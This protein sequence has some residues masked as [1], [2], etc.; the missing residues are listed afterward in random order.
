M[1]KLSVTLVPRLELLTNIPFGLMFALKNVNSTA[2]LDLPDNKCLFAGIEEISTLSL[3]FGTK[4]KK[5]LNCFS[6]NV[7]CK[8]NV[9]VYFLGC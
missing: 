4:L 1:D 3:Q 8:I 6:N 2:H 5:V 7:N 9:L